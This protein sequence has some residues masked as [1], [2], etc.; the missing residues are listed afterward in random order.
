MKL[1]EFHD[2]EPDYYLKRSYES[3]LAEDYGD[4]NT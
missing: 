2:G 3:Y 1:V 4:R